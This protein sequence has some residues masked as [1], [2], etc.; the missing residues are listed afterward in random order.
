MILKIVFILKS[1]LFICLFLSIN[2]SSPQI[3]WGADYLKV[4][5]NLFLNCFFHSSIWT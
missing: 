3:L 2:K 1:D 5:F 4:S